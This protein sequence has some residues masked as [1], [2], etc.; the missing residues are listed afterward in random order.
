[1]A[2]GS[3]AG[4]L[5]GCELP[6]QQLSNPSWSPDDTKLV[7][8][9]YDK[10]E[11]TEAERCYLEV[12]EVA[13]LARTVILEGPDGSDGVW[14]CYEHPRWSPDGSEVVFTATR[15]EQSGDEWIRAGAPVGVASTAGPA[16]QEPRFLTDAAF[17]AT[18]P[19]WHP[20]EDLITFGTRH[21]AENQDVWLATNVYT[22]RSDGSELTQVTEYGD[23][24][25][26]ATYPTW[27]P[28]G[29]RILFNYILP[30]TT[31]D[32]GARSFAYISPDG[33]GHRVVPGVSGHEGRFR[34]VP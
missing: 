23:G 5:I 32:G 33:T 12:I 21:L 2:D 3:D 8:Q 26:R 16:D 25:V 22:I 17:D 7:V 18:H 24:D 31:G 20:S 34:P 28:D 13:T 29:E 11:G 30:V 15:W 14:D 4:P 6:C 9:R 19:D 1:M 10:V 27:T